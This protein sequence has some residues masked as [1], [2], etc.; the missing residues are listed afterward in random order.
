MTESHHLLSFIDMGFISRTSLW[1]S[2]PWKEVG[3][4]ALHASM[5]ITVSL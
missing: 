4:W 5:E 1:S 2:M 3:V